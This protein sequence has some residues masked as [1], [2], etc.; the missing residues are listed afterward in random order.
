METEENFEW[1]CCWILSNWL[2][3]SSNVERCE[4]LILPS[5]HPQRRRA[6]GSTS[7]VVFD[8]VAGREA[9]FIPFNA[10]QTIFSTSSIQLASLLLFF[11]LSCWFWYFFSELIHLHVLQ[12]S[13]RYRASER[14]LA[15]TKSLK[16]S[17]VW[18]IDYWPSKP[19]LPRTWESPC[20][21]ITVEGSFLPLPYSRSEMLNVCMF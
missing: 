12:G 7:F 9:L 3:Y 16:S 20:V 10:R 17:L 14:D 19:H 6:G 8:N 4:A 13:L 2:R 11:F 15:T 5:L 18:G 21:V 1:K